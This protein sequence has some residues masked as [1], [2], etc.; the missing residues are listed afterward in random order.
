MKTRRAVTRI[1]V[2]IAVLIVASVLVLAGVILYDSAFPAQRVIDLTNVTYPGP[3][4][5][6]LHGYLARPTGNGPHPAVLMIHEFYGLNRDIIKKADLLAGQGYV[7]LAADSYRGQTTA[8]IPRAIFLTVT[9]PQDRI[10]SDLDAAS[11]YLSTVQG[12]DAL[13]VGAVGFCFGGTQVMK[14]GT[15]NGDLAAAVIFYGS[16]PITDPAALGVMGR[17]GPVL[18]IYGELDQSIPLAEVR[19]FE[20]AMQ[21]RGV[22]H[23]VTVYPGVG[24]AFVTSASLAQ[25]GAAQQA[26]GEMLA[27]LAQN[28][29]GQAMAELAA[30]PEGRVAA[31]TGAPG[32]LS[33]LHRLH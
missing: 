7:V 3:N 14:M 10:A 4:G 24:H 11:R 6:T 26:W 19:G 17:R 12:V 33:A 2:G 27:F 28:L 9:T 15:R 23:R 8:L 25:T 21:A 29:K 22:P 1:L 16:G 31:P 32:I 30:P 20:L 5:V 18:G 13:R